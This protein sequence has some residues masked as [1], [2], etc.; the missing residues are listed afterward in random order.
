MNIKIKILSFIAV[1]GIVF[2]FSSC[3]KQDFKEPTFNC[4]SLNVKATYTIH[5]LLA[6]YTTDDTIRLADSVIIE[7]TVISTD[8][9]GNFYK[10]LV[11]QDSTAA[12]CLQ[13]D[14]SY[15]YTMFPLGQKIYVKCG[16]LLLGNSAG[17]IKLGSTYTEY[18]IVHFGRIQGKSVV[19]EHLINSCENKP[20]EPQLV[21]LGQI[22]DGLVYKLVKIENVQFK[23]T[24]LHTTYADVPNLTAI[25]HHI[26]DADNHSL[27]VRTSGYANFAKDSLPNG[28]GTIVGVLGKYNGTYQLYPRNST[29]VDFGNARFAEPI[30]QNFESGDILSDGWTNYI[31]KG[32]AWTLG[33]HSSNNYGQC[34]NYDGSVHIPTESWYISPKLDLSSFA[35]PFLSFK[36]AWGYFG[37]EITVKYSTNYDGTSDPNTATW[38]KLN[39]TLYTGSDFWTWTNSGNLTLPTDTKYVAFIY[40]GTSSDGRTW[41]I[42]D[43]LIDDSSK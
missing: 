6:L 16:N 21:N 34:T 12:I 2:T 14:A 35:S 42:D 27:I 36:S 38:T 3:V 37:D 19:E 5:D 7:G 25:D 1:L 17:V 30:A 9:Y 11:I 15:M 33:N 39:P 13:I 20:V 43:I 22:D 10:E 8:Q 28:N 29:D 40:T 26:V 41:E 32:V 18:G 4:D 23:A 31:V 24:E